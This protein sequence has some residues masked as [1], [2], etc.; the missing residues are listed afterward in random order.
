MLQYLWRQPAS[1]PSTDRSIVF[2]RWRPYVS[3][4]IHGLVGPYASLFPKR[5][6]DRFSRFCTDHA[7]SSRVEIVRIQWRSKALRGPGSTVTLGPSIHSAG[8]KGQ[9]WKSEVLRAEV[10]LWGVSFTHFWFLAT[11][12]SVFSVFQKWRILFLR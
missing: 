11:Y 4:I 7:K 6:R 1:P 8:P 10:G 2:A 9:N 3:R 12:L 5:H